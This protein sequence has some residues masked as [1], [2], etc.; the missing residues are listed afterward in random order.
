MNNTFGTGN[1]EYVQVKFPLF[2]LMALLYLCAIALDFLCTT[3]YSVRNKVAHSPRQFPV[4]KRTDIHIFLTLINPS[5]QAFCICKVGKKVVILIE[6]F[7]PPPRS[8]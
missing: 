8:L 7:K 6:G 5:I 1:E 2:V 4:D 3:S